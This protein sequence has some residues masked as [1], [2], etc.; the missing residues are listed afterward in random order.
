METREERS[1]SVGRGGHTAR[2]G[3]L[4]NT[5]RPLHM[6]ESGGHVLKSNLFITPANPSYTIGYTVLNYKGFII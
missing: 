4:Q 6:S 3:Q 5:A 1:A 2:Y